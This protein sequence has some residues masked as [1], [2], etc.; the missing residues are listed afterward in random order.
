MNHEHVYNTRRVC[1]ICHLSDWHVAFGIRVL[2]VPSWVKRFMSLFLK[3]WLAITLGRTI[4]AARH[5][6]DRELEHELVHA[7]QWHAHGR[8]FLFRYIWASVRAVRAG[9]HWYRDNEY[10]VEARS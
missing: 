3:N 4:F 9:G 2:L 1:D 5:M 8:T 6:S 7:A 10:E